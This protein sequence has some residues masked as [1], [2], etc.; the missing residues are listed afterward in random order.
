MNETMKQA[1][2][3]TGG[4]VRMAT[5]QDE[6]TVAISC[7]GQFSVYHRGGIPSGSEIGFGADAVFGALAS[8]CTHEEAA[9]ALIAAAMTDLWPD[10][11]RILAHNLKDYGDGYGIHK[12]LRAL[13]A[14]MP[15]SEYE[16]DPE[17][18]AAS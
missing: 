7:G 12:N 6:L 13:L 3:A 14:A 17:I 10:R 8:L 2:E 5:G 16:D 15:P 9:A 1:A 18:P 4:V 11:L